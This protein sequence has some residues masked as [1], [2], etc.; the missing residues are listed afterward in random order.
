MDVRGVQFPHHFVYVTGF[1]RA[2]QTASSAASTHGEI[3]DVTA[4]TRV[5]LGQGRALPLVATPAG[6]VESPWR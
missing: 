3:V 2:A 1:N 6:V 4:L 5:S